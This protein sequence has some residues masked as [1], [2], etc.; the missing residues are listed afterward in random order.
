MKKT[1]LWKSD[2]RW[3]S[4][5]GSYRPT[6]ALFVKDLAKLQ[7]M[8]NQQDPTGWW[9]TIVRNTCVASTL[10][11][12]IRGFGCPLWLNPILRT[13]NPM[14]WF[15]VKKKFFF[16]FFSLLRHYNFVVLKDENAD[17]IR[18]WCPYRSIPGSICSIDNIAYCSLRLSSLAGL[19]ADEIRSLNQ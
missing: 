17:Q 19:V 11:G 3:R 1:H 5:A 13:S 12:T 10:V 8:R 2:C 9:L 14:R 18:Q 15:I 7:S 16:F 4:I 6:S